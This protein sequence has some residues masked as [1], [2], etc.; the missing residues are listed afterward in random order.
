MHLYNNVLIKIAQI[1]VVISRKIISNLPMK[2]MTYVVSTTLHNF[3]QIR[4]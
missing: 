3:Q 1:L 4:A 2:F